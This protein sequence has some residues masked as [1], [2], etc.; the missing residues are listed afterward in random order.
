MTTSVIGPSLKIF[1]LLRLHQRFPNPGYR[2]RQGKRLDEVQPGRQCL[3][4]NL[5]FML[6]LSQ[7][8]PDHI[9]KIE[10][11]KTLRKLDINTDLACFLAKRSGVKVL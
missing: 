5:G 11:G 9:A 10:T 3:V 8:K 1:D 6:F 2:I 4:S 7:I